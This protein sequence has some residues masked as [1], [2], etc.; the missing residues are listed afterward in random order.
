MIN[1]V[2]DDLCRPAGV[3]FDASLHFKGLILHLDGLIALAL[4]WAT[5]ERQ[6]ILFGMVRA[7][8]LD[9]LGIEH[10]GVRG[11]SS[12]L[13]KKGDDALTYADHICRHADT[14]F[15]VRHQ[16]IKQVLGDLQIFFCCDL[17]L[18]CKEDGI[19]HQFFNHI[20]PTN[21]N[22]SP[23]IVFVERAFFLSALIVQV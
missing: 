23:C 4:S 8:F 1:L 2:L 16:R 19:V 7:V 13:V 5:E 10:H 21:W 14:A 3:G 22:L 15:S 9:N 12:T 6:A 11:S 20:T 18:P 17:R